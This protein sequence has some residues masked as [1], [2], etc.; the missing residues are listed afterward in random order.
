MRIWPHFYWERGARDS[1]DIS[2]GEYWGDPAL[3]AAGYRPEGWWFGIYLGRLA[4][5]LELRRPDAL[6]GL[7]PSIL[8]RRRFWV[9]A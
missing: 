9:R 6:R 3:E 4:I 1:R 7:R 2:A 5:S 8:L